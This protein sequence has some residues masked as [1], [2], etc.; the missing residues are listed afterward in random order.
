MNLLAAGAKFV[1]API[2]DL[3]DYATAGQ[4]HN[5]LS[6]RFAQDREA[7]CAA[8]K[9]LPK[10][11]E[12]RI[13][14]VIKSLGYD[15]SKVELSIDDSTDNDSTEEMAHGGSIKKCGWCHLLISPT[16]IKKMD[17]GIEPKHQ[18]VIAHEMAHDVVED[19]IDYR[20]N[21]QRSRIR[22]SLVTYTISLLVTNY[23][24]PGFGYV[25]H[26]VKHGVNVLFSKY[27]GNE[28]QLKLHRDLEKACDLRAVQ[29]NP[30]LIQPAIQH[31]EDIRRKHLLLKAEDP[32]YAITDDGEDRS[33]RTHPH[34]SQ[35]IRYLSEERD[36]LAKKNLQK[37]VVPPVQNAAVARMQHRKQ[38][39]R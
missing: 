35:R 30:Q 39:R 2:V 1:F 7:I 21:H 20:V 32:S 17:K 31:Y 3:Y 10:A 12:D 14:K 6:R 19:G 25:G 23:V 24:F 11:Q 26:L 33:H 22:C 9:P 18:Y 29:G 15:S 28:W 37:T 8:Y 16:F 4:R 13:K 5:E 27:V 36:K 38:K 34:L